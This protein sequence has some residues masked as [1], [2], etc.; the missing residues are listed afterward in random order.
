[1]Q[2]LLSWS[3]CGHLS[4]ACQCCS[5]I[6][7]E[8]PPPPQ[9][10]EHGSALAILLLTLGLL[11]APWFKCC[12]RRC[13]WPLSLSFCPLSFGKLFHLMFPVIPST[14]KTL[15]SILV[16]LHPRISTHPSQVLIPHL[17]FQMSLCLSHLK[18]SCIFRIAMYYLL[19]WT[20]FSYCMVFSFVKA[21]PNSW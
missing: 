8:K 5:F 12:P 10:P 17:Y 20:N 21:P 2:G 3:G 7:C 6:S 16:K 4:P 18:S 11:P 14:K 13:L 19:F 9:L 1:M 15:K